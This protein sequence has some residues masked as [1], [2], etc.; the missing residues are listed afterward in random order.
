MM[1]LSM[2][3]A[4]AFLLPA[5]GP[6]FLVLSLTVLVRF[7]ARTNPEKPFSPSF[8]LRTGDA[9]ALSGILLDFGIL[10]PDALHHFLTPDRPLDSVPLLVSVVFLLRL[11]FFRLPALLPEAT[12]LFFGLWL[13]LSPILKQ[14]TLR[15]GAFET[16]TVFGLWGAIRAL[17][18]VD[19]K[20]GLDG[21]FLLPLFLASTALSA[22]S[23]LSGS[24]LVGQIAAGVA[25]VIAVP[26]LS[27]GK[28]RIPF[29]GIEPG[30][31]LGALLV[32]G[33]AYVD[34]SPLVTGSLVLSL[35]LGG[36]AARRIRSLPGLSLW[37]KA[38]LVGALSLVPLLAGAI[39]TLQSFSSGGGGY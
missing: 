19:R 4:L 30:W 29:S 26:V 25:A 37:K 2:P 8:L 9:I 21:L 23:A 28:R 32:I 27:G 12:A 38:A 36:A 31:A 14:T 1:S 22:F 7:L 20:T 6:F 39:R 35:L 34:L 15:E 13:L 5:T 3:P 11:L 33:R 24:L 18:S 10:D 16:L 17:F